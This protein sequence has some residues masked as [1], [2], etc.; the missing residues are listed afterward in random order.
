MDPSSAEDSC[1]PAL[2]K[3]TKTAAFA[4]R[5]GLS[6]EQGRSEQPRLEAKLGSV[7]LGCWGAGEGGTHRRAGLGLW[8]L[9]RSPV[10]SR[11]PP[12]PSAASGAWH[13]L[14]PHVVLGLRGWCPLPIAFPIP[15]VAVLSF[16]TP[17]MF[18][19]AVLWGFELS[20]ALLCFMW[21]AASLRRAPAGVGGSQ[22]APA[23]GPA[24][25]ESADR[26]GSET[27]TVAFSLQTAPCRLEASW[28]AATRR[29]GSQSLLTQHLQIA[30]G[31]RLSPK[32]RSEPEMVLLVERE[33]WLLS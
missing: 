33:H 9:P 13:H 16:K 29:A 5:A 30:D 31:A 3:Y 18:L 22:P 1:V 10:G 11:D 27:R 2:S 28:E 23:A 24:R 6:L 12:P 14:L 20:Q 21:D 4:A 15:G 19:W 32:A 8:L 26:S 7:C 25:A 17:P